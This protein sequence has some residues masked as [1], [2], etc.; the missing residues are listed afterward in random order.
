M[1]IN[2]LVAQVSTVKELWHEYLQCLEKDHDDIVYAMLYSSSSNGDHSAAPDTASHYYSL[3]GTIGLPSDQSLVPLT[4]ELDDCVPKTN[5]LASACCTAVREGEVVTLQQMDGTLPPEMAIGVPGRAAGEQVNTVCILPIPDMFSVNQRAFVVIALSP[6]RPYDSEYT[7]FVHNLRDVLLKSAS[8]IFL[9]EEHRRV[10][11]K[12][13]EIETNLAHQLRTTALEAQRIEA[14]YTK[15]FQLAPV[16]MFAI[17]PD[18]RTT[19]YNDAYLSITG[20]SQYEAELASAN[21]RD[22]IHEDDSESVME[23]WL[24]C[25][26]DK[27]PFTHEYRVRKQHSH[28][29]AA[30]GKEIVGDSWYVGL[31]AAAILD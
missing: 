11:Q 8:T 13:E 19:F 15:M 26:Q 22:A 28:I 16:G 6:R 4:F 7:T 17:T 21:T 5:S 24:R 30:S 23:C 29:D 27:L 10:R 18:S 2:Q 31:D 1:R 3:E 20:I 9:P 25:L 14:Q 12:F